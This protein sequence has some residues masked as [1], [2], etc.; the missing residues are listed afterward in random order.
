LRQSQL[1]WGRWYEGDLTNERITVPYSVAAEGR[2]GAVRNDTYVLFRTQNGPNVV[3]YGLGVVDFSLTQAQATFTPTQGAKSL[4]SVDGGQLRIDF[5]RSQFST[6]LELS[7]TAT[8]KVTFA[9]SGTVF[10]GG[11]FH[12]PHPTYEHG[13]AGAVS[14]DGTEAG[15]VF[16]EN[17]AN[18]H[19]EGLTL[20]SSKP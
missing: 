11:F 15:Y 5:D 18:G 6:S 1:L 7:H 12:S 14:L 13:M 9:D 8:G 20:W 17:I 10:G 2:A 4:M 3:K 19:I 16:D